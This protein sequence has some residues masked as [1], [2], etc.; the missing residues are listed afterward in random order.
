MF[1]LFSAYLAIKKNRSPW[2]WFFVGFIAT[3]LGPILLFVMKSLP[4][5]PDDKEDDLEKFRKFILLK[6]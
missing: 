6:Y 4:R 3:I 1:G 5:D 2:P